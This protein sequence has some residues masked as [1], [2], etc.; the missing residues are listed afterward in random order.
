[1][2]SQINN[3]NANFRFAS[4]SDHLKTMSVANQDQ[5]PKDVTG[6][7]SFWQRDRNRTKKTLLLSYQD[8]DI[9]VNQFESLLLAP[10]TKVTDLAGCSLLWK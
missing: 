8:S 6:N 9:L 2:I 7:Q 3:M 10:S 4:G 5:A 1:M